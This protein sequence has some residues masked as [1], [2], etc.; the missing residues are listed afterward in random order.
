ME[1]IYTVVTNGPLHVLLFLYDELEGG[2]AQLGHVVVV[3]GGGEELATNG[4]EVE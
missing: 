3:G 4:L 2:V 1:P